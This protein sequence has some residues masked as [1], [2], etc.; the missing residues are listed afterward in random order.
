MD[1]V[2]SAL[3][4]RRVDGPTV[5][6]ATDNKVKLGTLLSAIPDLTSGMPLSETCH[7][8]RVV[9]KAPSGRPGTYR[10]SFLPLPMMV[11]A[12][13]ILTLLALAAGG[14]A[15][16]LN[17]F[18]RSQNIAEH[19]RGRARSMTNP[20]AA[21]NGGL[22]WKRAVFSIPATN[23]VL[24]YTVEIGIGNPPTTYE[25]IVDT[26]SGNTL[27]QKS[28]YK[29][30]Q[31]SLRTGARVS[32]N[33]AIG[34][35]FLDRVIIGTQVIPAQSLG[36]MNGTGTDGLDCILG[37]GP[38]DLT[39]GTISTG[40]TVPTVL[41]NLFQLG[42]IPI[43]EFGVFFSPTTGVSVTDGELTFGGID[44][45][46]TVGS[47]MFT[48]VTHV[49][50]SSFFWGLDLSV[51]YGSSP[52]SPTLSGILD[53]STT[54]ILLPTDIFA[55]YKAAAGATLSQTVGLLQVSNAQFAAM[56]NFNFRIGGAIFSLTPN[57]QL[58]PRALNVDIGGSSGD[59][60]LIIGDVG[61]PSGTG[62]DFVL[63][64]AFSERFYSVY[65]AQNSSIG[66]A[67]TPLTG[68]ITN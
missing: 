16:K 31:T 62:F 43:K 32:V 61:T 28:V 59:N 34:Q 30:T 49:A 55:A 6:V 45:N 9:E 3:S 27:I 18:S 33:G 37:L 17:R 66:V 42:L 47:L 40:G 46:H 44:A 58:F 19:D 36:V 68:A 56:K 64:M 63:G 13:H 26:G 54:L 23:Q 14:K 15:L 10:T 39:S 12:L 7:C 50:P 22:A 52:F 53:T 60:F 8:Q 4:S 29:I 11:L 67:K 24:L 51:A 5:R 41:D 21:G 2:A 20:T 25:C 48:P 1:V 38:T 57:A 35:E 65:N